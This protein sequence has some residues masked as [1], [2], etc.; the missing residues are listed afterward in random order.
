MQFD[1]FLVTGKLKGKDRC[2]T[3]APSGPARN[4]FNAMKSVVVEKDRHVKGRDASLS[5]LHL[6]NFKTVKMGD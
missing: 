6:G 2:I 3:M 5:P 1:R 4:A